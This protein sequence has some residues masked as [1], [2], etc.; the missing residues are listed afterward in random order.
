MEINGKDIKL[1][2]RKTMWIGDP[3]IGRRELSAFTSW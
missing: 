3:E 2:V 1:D